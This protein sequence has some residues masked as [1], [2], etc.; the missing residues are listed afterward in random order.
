MAAPLIRNFYYTFLFSGIS[1]EYKIL[2]MITDGVINDMD[3]TITAIIEASYTPLSIIIVGVGSA[4][5]TD[6][7]RLDSD[8]SLLELNGKKAARDIVQFVS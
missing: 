7:H 5:F 6:M 8:K 3:Q 4:D 2:L 1:P